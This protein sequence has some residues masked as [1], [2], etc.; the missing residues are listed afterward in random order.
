VS[1]GLKAL[2]AV[3]VVIGL[4]LVAAGIVYFLVKAGSLPSFIPGKIAHSTGHR[5]K[6][7]II[8]IVAGVVVLI[9]AVVVASVG[10]RRRYRY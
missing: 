3:L 9:I 2:V 8:G 7:G 6:R 5:N 4:L 1:A 10:R